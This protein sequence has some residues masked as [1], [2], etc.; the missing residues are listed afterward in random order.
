VTL[1][2]ENLDALWRRSNDGDLRARDE[3]VAGYFWL[4]KK[5]AYDKRVP[6]HVERDDLISWAAQGLLEAVGR[7]DIEQSDGA[8][9]KHFMS[10][11]SMRIRG[12]ILDGLKSPATSWASRLTWRRLKEQHAVEDELAQDL[13]RAP[14]RSEVAA[15]LGVDV[16]ELVH[17]RQQIPIGSTG[18]AG[19]EQDHGLEALD[20]GDRTDEAADAYAVAERV[21]SRIVDLPDEHQAVMAQLYFHNRGLG[22]VA[23]EFGV[24]PSRIRKTRAEALN[25][26]RV[27]FQAG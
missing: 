7:F 4:A 20:G 5:I 10:Y 3:L 21:A 1:D 25:M 11:A 8:L 15:K 16:D 23:R 26:L 18:Q 24:A 6:D 12:A 19:D 27:A 9:H 22:E 14:T 13:G 2:L 17:L